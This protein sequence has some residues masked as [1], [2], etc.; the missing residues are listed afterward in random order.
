MGL[1]EVNRRFHFGNAS[2]RANVRPLVRGTGEPLAL[3]CSNKACREALTTVTTT[4]SPYYAS[5]PIPKALLC[6]LVLRVTHIII[7]PISRLGNRGTRKLSKWTQ[8]LP[9]AKKQ[10]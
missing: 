8:C 3:C 2:A 10:S 1:G 9:V 6:H 7:N 5:G 4:N